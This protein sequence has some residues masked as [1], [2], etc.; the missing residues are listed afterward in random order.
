MTHLA[1]NFLR[2]FLIKFE[3]NNFHSSYFFLT[4]FRC[5]ALVLISWMNWLLNWIFRKGVRFAINL[6]MN[7]LKNNFSDLVMLCIMLN[8]VAIELVTVFGM[9]LTWRYWSTLPWNSFPIFNS[10]EISIFLLI[11]DHNAVGWGR[12][13]SDIWFAA[14]CARIVNRQH[15]EYHPNS[16]HQLTVEVLCELVTVCYFTVDRLNFIRELIEILFIYEAR[17]SETRDVCTTH[18]PL[19]YTR[20]VDF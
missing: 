14:R 13:K 18:T 5:A 17:E 8:G 11:F 6:W 1:S 9:T 20:N 4:P 3:N 10:L 2:R 16:R 12:Y 15:G 7:S 19:R